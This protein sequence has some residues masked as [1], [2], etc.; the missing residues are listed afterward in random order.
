MEGMMATVAPIV[1]VIDG[2]M[3]HDAAI[4]SV[5]AVANVSAGSFVFSIDDIRWRA[6]IAGA[7]ISSACNYAASPYL[8]WR[9]N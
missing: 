7:V 9:K 5:G 1:G 4:S 2:D 3:Q 8:T 6:G